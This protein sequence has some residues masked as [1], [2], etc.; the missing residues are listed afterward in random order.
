MDPSLDVNDTDKYKD[1][2]ESNNS[3]VHNFFYKPSANVKEA[4]Y[5][6]IFECG[7][8]VLDKLDVTYQSAFTASETLSSVLPAADY[9]SPLKKKYWDVQTENLKEKMDGMNKYEIRDA[10][11]QLKHEDPDY[12]ESILKVLINEYYEYSVSCEGYGTYSTVSDEFNKLLTESDLDICLIDM[13]N[14]DK[15][16]AARKYPIKYTPT[17]K[18]PITKSYLGK[19]LRQSESEPTDMIPVD[20]RPIHQLSFIT[21]NPFDT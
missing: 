9:V 13:E 15:K 12:H 18:A 6:N 21:D 19:R 17:L 11:Y 5:F 20:M 2:D 8:N 3:I 10:V 7:R 4:S 1:E 14:L 16:P